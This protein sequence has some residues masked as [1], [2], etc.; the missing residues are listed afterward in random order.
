MGRAFSVSSALSEPPDGVRASST[1]LM[2]SLPT[3]FDITGRRAALRRL[4]ACLIASAVGYISH[5]YGKESK[6]PVC[7]NLSALSPAEKRQRRLDNYIENSPDPRKTCSGCSFFIAATEPTACGQCQIFNGPA[8]P[9]GRCD[10]WT[11]RSV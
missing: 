6:T 2:T 5:G 7:I 1:M 10:D 4:S 3:S 9:K 8:N 11:A